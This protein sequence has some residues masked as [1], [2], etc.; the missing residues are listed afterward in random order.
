VNTPLTCAA[1]AERLD[2]F[3]DAELPGPELLEVARHAAVCSR[4][5]GRV[6]ELLALH[7][8]VAH[9]METAVASLDLGP[10]WPGV[11]AAL[12]E[13]DRRRAWRR[14]ARQV[15]AIAAAAMAMAAGAVLW[16]RPATPVRIAAPAR[17]NQAVVE[18][19]ASDGG[20]FELR[21]DRKLGTTLIMVSAVDPES[22]P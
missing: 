4:C 22:Y 15:P 3:V 19:I 2:A 14:R 5:D 7:E 12:A 13:V 16:M 17:P 1:A 21:R 9:Q 11:H 10:V 6:G 8:A 18:R 20:R